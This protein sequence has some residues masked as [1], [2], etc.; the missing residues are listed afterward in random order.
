MQTGA[1]LRLDALFSEYRALAPD[2]ESSETF[3]PQLWQRI[4]ARRNSTFLVRRWAQACV[5]ATLALALLVTA[6]V[7]PHYQA[8]LTRT[9]TPAG[10]L[11]VLAAADTAADNAVLTAVE[12]GRESE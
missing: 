2:P 10:Y 11:D 4:E 3:M 6:F 8:E 9:A 7:L 12:Q 5:A 1:E